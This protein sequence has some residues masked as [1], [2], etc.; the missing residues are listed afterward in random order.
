VRREEEDE[1][2]KIATTLRKLGKAAKVTTLEQ[3]DKVDRHAAEEIEAVLRRAPSF[4]VKVVRD[5]VEAAADELKESEGP[6]AELTGISRSVARVVHD[7]RNVREAAAALDQ[8]A[9]IISRDPAV[10]QMTSQILRTLELQGILGESELAQL[11]QWLLIAAQSGETIKRIVQGGTV[12]LAVGPA[13]LS[14]N[15]LGDYKLR[16]SAPNPIWPR[17]ALKLQLSGSRDR[18]MSEI[19]IQ[20]PM[21]F[22]ISPGSRRHKVLVTPYFKAEVAE[23][24]WKREAARP[25]EEWEGGVRATVRF[26]Q[27]LV[28]ERSK[29]EGGAVLALLLLGSIVASEWNG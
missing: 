9:K 26:G 6:S 2:R 25:L 19:G 8:V 18:P 11:V 15:R 10:K 24:A 28:V 16:L 13:A 22:T 7:P 1:V 27:H 29:H 3:V 20:T 14:V 17:Q 5:T 23:Q 4:L 12:A 21:L